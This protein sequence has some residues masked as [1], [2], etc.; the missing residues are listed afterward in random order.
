[1]HVSNFDR[2]G[3][4]SPRYFMPLGMPF[5]NGSYLQPSSEEVTPS[6]NAKNSL[7]DVKKEEAIQAAA[8]ALNG[9]DVPAVKK[10][11]WPP[12]GRKTSAPAKKKKT[13]KKVAKEVVNLVGSEEEEE[14]ASRKWRNYEV[15]TLISIREEIEE[16]FSRCA[17]K[18]SLYM[19]VFLVL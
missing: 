12:K 19:C 16:E 10:R 7:M 9:E 2:F 17:K 13:T 11:G 4:S 5:C 3:A 1:M 8:K 6:S 14:N 15:E 18:Q